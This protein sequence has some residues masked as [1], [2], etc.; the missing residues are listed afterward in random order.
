MKILITGGTGFIGQRLIEKRLSAGDDIYCL[1]RDPEKVQMLFPSEVSALSK[2]PKPDEIVVDAVINLA[3]EPILDKRWSDKRKQQLRGSRIEFTHDL[4]TWIEQQTNKPKAL[5]SGS[6]IGF[7]GSQAEGVL[8]EES[9]SQPGFTYDLC[10]EWENAAFQAKEF[11][12]RVCTIRTGIVLGEGGALAKMIPPFR[13]GLG[14][15]IGK[16]SQWMSWIHI[17]D[18]IDIIEMLLTHDH[19]HGSF[20]LT[21]P[22]AVTNKQFSTTLGATLKRPAFMPMPGFVMELLLG[23]GAE[24]LLEGQ[25]VY[26]KKLLDL[27][28]QFKFADLES[29]LR[30]IVEK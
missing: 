26:P 5:I 28:Y 14:G 13:F 6:A 19:L 10:A 23:E 24:L 17:D 3:G 20:N 9:S 18:E 29:A 1:T 21:S 15:P 8:D 2:L 4:V 16:G 12:L 7:Y 11:G 25:N 30:D 22:N 27:G